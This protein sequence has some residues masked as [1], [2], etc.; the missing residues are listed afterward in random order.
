MQISARAGRYT[1][2]ETLYEEYLSDADLLELDIC[3][4][5]T[6]IAIWA[7]E[8]TVIPPKF[9][10]YANVTTH[11][12]YDG[13]VYVEATTRSFEK[14]CYHIGRCV[15]EPRNGALLI[16]NTADFALNLKAG[17]ILVRADE[18]V[19]E[20]HTY[21]DNEVWVC[22]VKTQSDY[23]PFRE[24]DLNIDVQV[25]YEIKLKLLQLVNKYRK[26]FS[27]NL[28]ELETTHLTE[29]KIHV[30]DDRPVTYRP[31]RLSYSQ[32]EK[33]KTMILNLKDNKIIQDSMSS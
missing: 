9:M 30:N 26:T 12:D 3:N 32:R 7:K 8:A 14:C 15:L 23:K 18:C 11:D 5:N 28:Q 21:D 4:K 16:A 20:G 19:A 31:Y 13:T 17:Q 22:N 2:P 1:K 10:D 24:T 6:K 25:P 33:V 27:E 29:M